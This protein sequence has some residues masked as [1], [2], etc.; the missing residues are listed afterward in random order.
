MEMCTT[1]VDDTDKEGLNVEVESREA[2]N[3]KK[4]R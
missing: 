4:K 2:I 3:G 1:G